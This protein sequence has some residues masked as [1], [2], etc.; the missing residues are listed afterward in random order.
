MQD[1]D[2]AALFGD[3]EAA[4][5]ADDPLAQQENSAETRPTQQQDATKKT[6]KHDPRGIPWVH[7]V[8]EFTRKAPEDLHARMNDLLQ[9]LR[10]NLKVKEL[11]LIT[12]L[13]HTIH[14]AYY[15]MWIRDANA[16]FKRIVILKRRM[17]AVRDNKPIR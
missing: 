3:A 12:T 14:D 15:R 8:P 11:F 10:E 9:M 6:K 16:I 2:I 4:P 5:P 13:D 1:D 17:D 7:F